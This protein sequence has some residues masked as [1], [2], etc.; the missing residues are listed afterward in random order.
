MKLSDVLSVSLTKK[1]TINSLVM[2]KAT[3]SVLRIHMIFNS[4]LGEWLNGFFEER[5]FYV[6]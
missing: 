5:K 1:N 4:R 6:N 3:P 2:Y